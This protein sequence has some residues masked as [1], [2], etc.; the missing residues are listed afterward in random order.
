MIAVS[1][2]FLTQQIESSTAHQD[3][4]ADELV[5]TDLHK[6]FTTPSGQQSD[7]L[8]S[9]SFS[10]SPGEMIAI[11]G[12]SGAG[13]STLLNLIAGLDTTDSGAITL[14]GV[15]IHQA[16]PSELV[17]LRNK[18]I[19]LIFQFHH[20]LPGLTAVENVAMPQL[21]SRVPY[22]KAIQR[23][24]QKLSEAGLSHRAEYQVTHLSG[25]E[26]Q[27]VAVLR[28]LIN[29][30]TLV[31]AD[32]PTGNLDSVAANEIGESLQSY[33]RKYRAICILATHNERMAMR[34]DRMLVL[35]DGKLKSGVNSSEKGV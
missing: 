3:Q 22:R 31:L 8:K 34:C 9:V 20:L 4:G 5:V 28:A 6:S 27:R 29:R 30:P 11:V 18:R 32:E 24:S 15:A 21:I 19:G 7:V 23:A 12:V 33:C 2:P 17:R 26:Q 25:G 35:S 13:K 1:T 16:A 14:G 10:A